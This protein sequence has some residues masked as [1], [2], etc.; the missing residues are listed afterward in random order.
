MFSIGVFFY[1]FMKIGMFIN[2]LLIISIYLY[3]S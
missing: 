2:Q 1:H 3:L